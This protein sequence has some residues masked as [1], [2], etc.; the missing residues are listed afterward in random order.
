[1][2]VIIISGHISKRDDNLGKKLFLFWVLK[3]HI[4]YYFQV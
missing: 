3:F 1:M 4:D 2:M